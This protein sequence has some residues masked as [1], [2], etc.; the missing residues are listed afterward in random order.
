MGELTSDEGILVIR[1]CSDIIIQHVFFI[2]YIVYF[3]VIDWYS[4]GSPMF[5]LFREFDKII[6]DTI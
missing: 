4:K 1:V 2:Q 3:L 5:A 6:N